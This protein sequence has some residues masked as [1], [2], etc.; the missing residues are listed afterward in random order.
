M[1]KNW[2]VPDIPEKQQTPAVK[3][4]LTLLEQVITHNQKLSEEVEHLKD[5]INILKGEK[6]RP[7]FK[8]RAIAALLRLCE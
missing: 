7:T 6:R 3:A 8:P 2:V 4:L 1:S 5:E